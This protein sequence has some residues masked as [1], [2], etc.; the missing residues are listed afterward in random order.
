MPLELARTV[1]EARDHLS[2]HLRNETATDDRIREHV[3]IVAGPQPYDHCHYA[4]DQFLQFDATAAAVT[5]VY[6]QRLLRVT[7]NFIRALTRALTDELGAR[8]GEA[9]Y[10]IGKRWGEADMKAFVPRVEQEYGCA[11]D[12]LGMGVM[13]ETWWWP[14][15]AAGWG[16]WRHD[17]SH[18]RIGLVFVDL[19]H[20]VAAQSA[21]KTGKPACHLYAGLYSAVFGFLAHRELACTELECVAKGDA[22]CRFLIAAPRRIEVALSLRES[23]ATIDQIVRK[24]ST[25]STS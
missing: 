22:Q 17:F 20:S 16:V 24:I 4:A 5:N 15:R 19:H 3:R 13:L 10:A 7:D 8:A 1:K 14:L 2:S 11:F 12:K 21:G 23:G 9:M 25:L 18:S 6:G